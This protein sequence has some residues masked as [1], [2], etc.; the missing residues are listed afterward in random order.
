ME[1][2]GQLHVLAA[3]LPV[4]IE[5]EAEWSPEPVWTPWRRENNSWSSR[6]SNPSRSAYTLFTVL[7]DL[8]RIRKFRSCSL[9]RHLILLP[10]EPILHA[11]EVMIK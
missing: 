5:Q 11:A 6:K 7:I 2:S 1:M 10:S 3:L 4:P 9:S 8:P